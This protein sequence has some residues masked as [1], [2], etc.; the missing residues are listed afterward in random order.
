VADRQQYLLM[1]MPQ[2]LFVDLR[3]IIERLRQAGIRPILAH[4]ERCPELLHEPGQLEQLI[5][6]GCLV[7]VSSGSITDP[8]SR[9]DERALCDWFKRKLVHLLGSDGH[10]PTRRPPKMAE[11]YRRI[12]LWA[13]G[14][15]ADRICSTNGLGVLE[16][17]SLRIPEPEPRRASW[18]SR[19]W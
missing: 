4:P 16:G 10:S 7:Q 13:G 9:R 3:A 1:E 8:A 6:A 15:T 17:F 19:F 12:A 5:H 14:G 2:N 18:L 11:A